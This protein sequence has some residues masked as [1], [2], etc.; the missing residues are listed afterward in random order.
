MLTLQLTQAEMKLFQALP[1]TVRNGWKTEEEKLTF[2]DTPSR[3]AMRMSVI[4]L[5]DPRL[6]D[7]RKNIAELQ[8]K[9]DEAK[10]LIDALDFSGMSDDDMIQLFYA[11]GPDAVSFII[12]QLLTAKTTDDDLKMVASLSM[13]RHL[14]LFA[15]VEAYS[16]PFYA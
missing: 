11:M 5:Q 12:M 13:I 3:R 2:E 8:Q 16:S 6:L 10:E 14:T 9:P 4:Q 15:F 1:E 7:L